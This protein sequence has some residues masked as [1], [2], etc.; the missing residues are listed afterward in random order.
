M[1]ISSNELGSVVTY[2]KSELASFYDKN[3]LES[4]LYI[5]FQ[6]YFG[7]T[8]TAIILNKDRKLSESDLLLV[9]YAVKELKKYKPLAYIIGEWEFFGL[10]FFVNEY[11]LIPRPE[12]EELVQLIINDYDN[13]PPNNILDIGSGSGC[14]A[15]SLKYH[16][17][18]ATVTAWDISNEVLKV[19]DRNAKNLQLEIKINK[20]DALSNPDVNVKYDVIVS[21]PPYITNKE[22]D[23]M[24][25]NVLDYEPH[26]AL[27]VP[28]ENPLLFYERIANIAVKHLNKN[29]SLYVEINEQFGDEVGLLFNKKGLNKVEIVKDINDKN[30]MVKAVLS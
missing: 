27:F 3:E 5:L 11:V 21:N 30:R 26:L 14:I 10:S 28:D 2:F 9:I 16:F 29:G 19:I 24:H 23:Q 13:H 20:V 8:K 12:T 22:Q 25:S 6:H 1:K 18:N 17:K 15:L 7:V 4:M